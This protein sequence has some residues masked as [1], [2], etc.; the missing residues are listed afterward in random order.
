M[1]LIF[2]GSVYLFNAAR[3]P[4][5]ETFF[6]RVCSNMGEPLIIAIETSG[7]TGSVALAR[8][9][10][11]LGHRVFSAQTEH[12]RELLPALENLQ[13]ELGVP[14]SE[15]EQCYLSIGPGSFT[16]LR[17]AVTFAR[18][19]ALARRVRIVAISTL[20][21]IAENCAGDS[22]APSPL[23]VI[24]DAKKGQVFG[25]IFEFVKGGYVA[26]KPPRVVTPGEL[27]RT[28]SE[29]LWVTGEGVDYHAD[30]VSQAS[31]KIVDRS[32]WIPTATNV[33]RLGWQL[34]LTGSFTAARDLIP[35][36]LRRPEAEEVWE[37]RE[38]D[39]LRSAS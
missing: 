27:L 5:S 25:T 32:K 2:A 9:A 7:R 28:S 8:G 6:K 29:P 11:L 21:V 36:Y 33:H 31:A 37:K 23:A 4:T 39:K 24:L 18:H 10:A 26:S 19:L 3:Y 38:Q 12:A 22:D 20:S 30:A 13:T 1:L 15:I 14:T 35:V 17:V 34:A 16:G